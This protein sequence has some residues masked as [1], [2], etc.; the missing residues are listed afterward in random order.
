MEKN[1]RIILIFLMLLSLN[2]QK[3]KAKKVE[4][5]KEVG[6][7]ITLR[8]F[9]R[10]AVDLEGNLKW[11]LH[12]KETYYFTKEFRTVMY[13]VHVEQ[14]EKNK[15]KANIKADKG[16]IF[17]SENLMKVYGNIHLKTSD[18]KILEAEELLYNTENET[19]RS[20]KRVKIISAGTIIRG[21]GLEADK[22]L[23]KYK[24][25]KPEAVTI[26]GNPLKK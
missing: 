17:Q 2:C 22:S 5:D 24:I 20:D 14:F 21:V 23:D 6:S 9:S 19:I 25:L 11:R 4:N 15:V 26:S 12:A 10:D 18:G 13:D 7:T 16:E 8:D 3:N 1:Y